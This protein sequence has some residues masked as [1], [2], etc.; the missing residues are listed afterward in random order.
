MS[1]FVE[2]SDP[3]LSRP[4]A[5]VSKEEI[6]TPL[7]RELIQRMFKIARGEREHRDKKIMVGL[8]A[9]Q[10]GVAKRVIL[11][12][13]GANGKGGISQLKAYINPKIISRSEEEAEWYEGCYS[14]GC[15]TGIV[16]RPRVVTITAWNENGEEVAETHS[17][18][19]ARIFQHEIDHLDGKR[20]PSLITDDDKLHWVE[21]AQFPAYRNEEGWRHWPHKCPKEKW[22]KMIRDR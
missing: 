6:G 16:K 11:V 5:P 14:T 17:D 20:F 19:V 10:I 9:P 18:Y 1:D 15:V 21:E 22:L 2:P 8:A 7:L 12:D 13:I 3:I 4:S